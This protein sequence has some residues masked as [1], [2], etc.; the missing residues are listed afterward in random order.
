[1]HGWD[2]GEGEEAAWGLEETDG[3]GL[4]PP[5]RTW[6]YTSGECRPWNVPSFSEGPVP[7]FPSSCGAQHMAAG[8]APLLLLS[9]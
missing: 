9:P 4:Q 6:L 7:V 1:M 2:Q 8:R 3:L 5:A